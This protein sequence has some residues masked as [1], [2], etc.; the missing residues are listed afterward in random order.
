M[1]QVHLI[2]FIPR[3]VCLEVSAAFHAGVPFHSTRNAPVYLAA[4]T[5][6]DVC[7]VIGVICS[8]S[9]M[10]GE[11]DTDARKGTERLFTI[12]IVCI[13]SFGCW[14]RTEGS[15]ADAAASFASAVDALMPS[16]PT[17]YVP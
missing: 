14:V 5:V 7:L 16:E 3:F 15:A 2:F 4:V 17:E 12:P 1:Q 13:T 8:T 6:K 11:R 9:I 10:R